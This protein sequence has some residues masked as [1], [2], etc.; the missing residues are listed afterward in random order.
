MSD[1]TVPLGNVMVCTVCHRPTESW[2]FDMACDLDAFEMKLTGICLHCCDRVEVIS[3]PWPL[4]DQACT[5]DDR[6][7][8]G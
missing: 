4:T 6:S 8:H 7:G 5:S 1:E 2:S 3:T